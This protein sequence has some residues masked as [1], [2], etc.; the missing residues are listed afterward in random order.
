MTVDQTFREDRPQHAASTS[1]ALASQ[2]SASQASASQA[3]ASQALA[4]HERRR[5]EPLPGGAEHRARDRTRADPPIPWAPPPGST[6]G[7]TSWPRVY[8]G[9]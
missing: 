6:A 7:P 1:A 9:L 5:C 8:P 3:S 4:S 2:A